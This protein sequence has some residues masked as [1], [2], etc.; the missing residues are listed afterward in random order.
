MKAAEFCAEAA[1]LVSGAR[2]ETHGDAGHN[3][4]NIAMLW[5]AY[6]SIRRG[7]GKPLTPTDIAHMMALL[8]ISR[9]QLGAHAADDWADAIGYLALAGELS[10][11]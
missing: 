1:R 10:G 5:N 7:F 6:L 3:F 11:E 8:K 9:T 2:Q 4:E